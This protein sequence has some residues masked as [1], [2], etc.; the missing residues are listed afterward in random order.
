MF[1]ISAIIVLFIINVA[2][3]FSTVVGEAIVVELSKIKDDQE[4]KSGDN[5]KDYI[6]MFFI[7]KDINDSRIN[8]AT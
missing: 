4:E 3:S 8:G 5:A 6:S 7:F 2:L 1:V